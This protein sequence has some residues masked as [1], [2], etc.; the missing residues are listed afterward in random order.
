MQASGNQPTCQPRYFQSLA[1]TSTS[2][3][4]APILKFKAYRCSRRLNAQSV[5]NEKLLRIRDKYI[6]Y[7]NKPH[8]HQ[9]YF[10]IF[11]RFCREEDEKLVQ[12]QDSDS[13]SDE[14]YSP[15]FKRFFRGKIRVLQEDEIKKIKRELRF[16]SDDRF[17]NCDKENVKSMSKNLLQDCPN[18]K[19]EIKTSQACSSFNGQRLPEFIKFKEDPDEAEQFAEKTS[20]KT[21]SKT[22]KKNQSREPTLIDVID[23]T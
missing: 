18:K 8:T 17:D 5:Y 13:L 20:S 21:L 11:E 9:A 4:M 1:I 7:N 2:A 10:K 22:P 15:K 16:T 23:L 3:E 14:E 12:V 19:P 6:E